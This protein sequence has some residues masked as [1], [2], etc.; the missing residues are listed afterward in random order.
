MNDKYFVPNKEDIYIGYE[1]QYHGMTTGGLMIIDLSD[2]GKSETIKEPDTKVYFSIKCGLD[3]LN[4]KTPQ[5]IYDLIDNSQIQ[6]PYLT[7]EQIEAE[8]WKLTD[9]KSPFTGE[10]YKFI[11]SWN[12]PGFNEPH[13]LTLTWYGRFSPNLAIR[14]EWESSWNRFDEYIYYGSCKDINTFRTICKLLE[15]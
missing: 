8:G 13:K 5:Q 14:Y 4:E 15:I 11:K 9:E 3:P 2:E 12:G 7:K 10:H 1:C 6:V